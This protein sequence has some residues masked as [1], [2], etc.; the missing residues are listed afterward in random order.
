MGPSIN[1]PLIVESVDDRVHLLLDSFMR[2]APC[3]PARSQLDLDCVHRALLSLAV[4]HP[5]EGQA[6]ARSLEA[7]RRECSAEALVFPGRR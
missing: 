1:A 6:V 7:L 3:S 4:E 2:R 5:D